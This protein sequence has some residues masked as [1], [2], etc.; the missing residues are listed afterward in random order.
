VRR[1]GWTWPDALQVPGIARQ[2]RL[3]LR[4]VHVQ[5]CRGSGGSVVVRSWVTAHARLRLRYGF[6]AASIGGV[7]RV[8][9]VLVLV[10]GLVPDLAEV[11][12]AVVHYVQTGHV[13]HTAADHGDLGDQGREH[14]CGTTQH[15]CTCCATQA[16]AP[17]DEVVVTSLD[18]DAA[19]P[20]AP[21]W[22]KLAAR[23]PDRP[24]RPPIS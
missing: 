17:A 11:G 20:L 24:F 8:L 2:R 21:L 4:S 23:E 19:K 6:R 5:R 10:H 18:G 13:A 15:R 12:E 7:V 1:S 16:V 22:L 3:L 14:G 9:L